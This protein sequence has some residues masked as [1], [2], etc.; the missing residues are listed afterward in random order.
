MKVENKYVDIFVSLVGRVH[1]SQ[2]YYTNALSANLV[3]ESFIFLGSDL[4]N[5]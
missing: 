3:S 4:C 1:K 2:F 5:C